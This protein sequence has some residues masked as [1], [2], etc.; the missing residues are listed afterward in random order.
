VNR[1]WA[2]R[3]CLLTVVLMLSA[4]LPGLARRML[5]VGQVAPDLT[6]EGMDGPV[7]LGELRDS[8]VVLSFWS[9][10]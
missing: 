1:A 4:C 10:T 6:V 5:P 2:R 9:S 8:V 3:R 7:S